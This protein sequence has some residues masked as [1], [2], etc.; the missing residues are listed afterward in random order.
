VHAWMCVC[1]RMCTRVHVCKPSVRNPITA[2]FQNSPS[3]TGIINVC[4]FMGEGQ[5]DR[6]KTL[7]WNS[8]CWEVQIFVKTARSRQGRNS[9]RV[10]FCTDLSYYSA[11]SIYSLVSS[12]WIYLAQNKV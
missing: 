4:F 9:Y 2:E 3:I 1:A 12:D 6:C 11:L 8:R 5:L 7:V 10:T